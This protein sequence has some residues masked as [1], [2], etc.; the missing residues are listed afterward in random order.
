MHAVDPAAAQTSA[1]GLSVSW[2]SEDAE[3][4]SLRFATPPMPHPLRTP[5]RSASGHS[6]AGSPPDPSWAG[7]DGGSGGGWKRKASDDVSGGTMVV[8]VPWGYPQAPLSAEFPCGT[9]V[10]GSSFFLCNLRG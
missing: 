4:L 5:Q 6:Q 1:T 8:R 9:Q 3:G 7:S 2:A 10:R